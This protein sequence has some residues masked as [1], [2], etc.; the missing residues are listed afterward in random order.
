MLSIHH[1]QVNQM[2]EQLQQM[3]LAT[4]RTTTGNEATVTQAK[5]LDQGM[6]V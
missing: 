1:M 3:E 6:Y 4:G 5:M 2:A